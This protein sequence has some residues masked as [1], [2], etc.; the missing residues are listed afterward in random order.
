MKR[1]LE[2]GNRVLKDKIR[3]LR[4]ENRTLRKLKSHDVDRLLGM[5]RRRGMQI[6]RM[7]PE[8]DLL[9]PPGSSN[10]FQDEFYERLHHYSFRLFLRDLIKHKDDARISHLIRYCTD[11]VASSYLHFLIEAGAVE[12]FGPGRFRVTQ[13][14]KSFGGI[15][16]WF[17][18]RLFRD[19]FA[20]PGLYGVRFKGTEKS[21]DYDLLAD[22][23]GWLVYIEVKSSP[24]RGIE[25]HQ[26]ASFL[27]RVEELIP[28]GAIF[29]NDTELRMKD[30][31][32]PFFE[33]ELARRARKKE[34]E[35]PK[36]DRLVDEI[37]VF[38]ESLYL[39]NS[40]KSVSGNLRFC[41]RHFL[42]ACK[43]KSRKTY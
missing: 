39:M 27:D 23:E 18:H 13:P 9:L 30:K 31:R 21:G 16:E 4:R 17:V 15:L 1:D 42:D 20:A 6:F 10:Y 3:A 36:T 12:M 32:V 37:F 11:E 38:G 29:F 41:L 26:V 19:E 8:D 28:H 40:R 34:M 35:I 14:V 22:L 7:N 24:P 43:E 33:E 5:F 2:K 25:L